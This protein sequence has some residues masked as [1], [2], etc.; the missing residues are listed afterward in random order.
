MHGPAV[1]AAPLDGVHPHPIYPV[2]QRLP[3][4]RRVIQ[5]RAV[6]GLRVID[7]LPEMPHPRLDG[8]R[9]IVVRKLL[10]ENERDFDGRGI[11]DGLGEQPD[12]VVEIRCGP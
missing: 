8:G 3:I 1:P 5:Y 7:G 11:A 10:R 12:H 6:G 4:P 2:Q 9:Q